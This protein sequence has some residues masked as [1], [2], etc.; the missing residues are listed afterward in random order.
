MPKIQR[1]EEQIRA[2]TLTGIIKKYMAKREIPAPKMAVKLRI[3]ESGFY[4]KLR[5]PNR[6]TYQEVCRMIK[7]L[8]IPSGEVLELMGAEPEERA[9]NVQLVLDKNLLMEIAREGS[10]A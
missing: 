9:V 3:S 6:F 5:E 10:R 1:S 8:Q 4:A 2:D 7:I